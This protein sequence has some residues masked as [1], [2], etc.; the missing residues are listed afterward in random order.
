MAR[1]AEGLSKEERYMLI[2]DAFGRLNA[3][4]IKLYEARKMMRI[5]RR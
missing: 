3:D 1:F 4:E 2:R 5:E